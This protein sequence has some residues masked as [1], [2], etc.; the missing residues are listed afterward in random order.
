MLCTMHK[1]TETADIGAGILWAN[2]GGASV[3]LTSAA[4]FQPFIKCSSAQSTATLVS[5]AR[6]WL[7][8][9]NVRSCMVELE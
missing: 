8:L 4:A 7:V 3:I 1:C 5:G 9:C 2:Y 6:Q